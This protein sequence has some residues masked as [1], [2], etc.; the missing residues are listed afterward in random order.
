MR[1][2]KQIIIKRNKQIARAKNSNPNLR[3]RGRE[4]LRMLVDARAHQLAP[5]QR[6]TVGRNG[7]KT[8]W[9]RAAKKTT[10]EE[11]RVET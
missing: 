7:S 2:G 5:H 10:A 9:C 4:K 1:R 6:S 3:H 8:E 11:V